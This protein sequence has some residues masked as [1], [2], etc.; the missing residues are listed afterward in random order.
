MM[1]TAINFTIFLSVL[2]LGI[3]IW[4]LIDVMQLSVMP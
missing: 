2:G 4:N 1:R 3:A